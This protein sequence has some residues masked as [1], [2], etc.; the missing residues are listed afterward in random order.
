MPPSSVP[1]EAMSVFYRLFAYS[2]PFFS[3][4]PPSLFYIR[5][6]V[7]FVAATG[8]TDHWDSGH[9]QECKLLRFSIGEAVVVRDL[10]S[11]AALNGRKGKVIGRQLEAGCV[12]VCLAAVGDQ[13]AEEICAKPAN[14]ERVEEEIL[15]QTRLVGSKQ[16]TD[17][18]G[19]ERYSPIQKGAASRLSGVLFFFVALI[20]FV[21]SC[22]TLVHLVKKLSD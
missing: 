7:R 2:F 17:S 4:S 21:L 11:A 14:L 8:Q 1:L 9:R 19:K 18:N 10:V 6:G 16:E 5:F 15:D 22:T 12:M 3:C 20:S 13:P